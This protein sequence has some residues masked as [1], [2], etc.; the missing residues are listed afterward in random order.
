MPDLRR[1]AS[2]F[3]AIGLILG[4]L[5]A[6]TFL[7]PDN[8]LKE[9]RA[10]GALRACTPATYLPLVTGDAERPG[11]DVELLRAV[12]AR[13]RVDL[14]L[15]V[16]DAIGRDFNP[17]NW[18]LSRAQCQIIAGGVVDSDQTRS[19]LETSP[20]HA[21]TG[22]AVISPQPVGD[23]KGLNVGVLTMV[24]GLDRIGLASFLRGAGARIVVVRTREEL[25]AGI[26]ERRFDA[27]VTEALLAA[28]L[29]TERNWTVAWAPASLPRYGLVF[30]LWKGDLTLKRAI[31]D[32]VAEL[33]ASGAIA[34]ILGR[35]AGA[36]LN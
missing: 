21:R 35:Y 11:I 33:A 8:S 13:L 28:R 4:L 3:G 24:S 27:G 6:V 15:N 10:G 22:W 12:A 32:A 14:A 26:A 9:V 23:W 19:F 1:V 7:P 34:A 2:N 36:P 25:V 20:P 31:D 16:N 29:A 17:R 5:L 30:G 18:G